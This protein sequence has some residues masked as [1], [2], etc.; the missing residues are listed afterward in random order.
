MA[1][2]QNLS[3]QSLKALGRM[4][5]RF[6]LNPV[7]LSSSIAPLERVQSDQ[8]RDQSVRS[9]HPVVYQGKQYTAVDVAEKEGDLHPE[10]MNL[11]K[12]KIKDKSSQPRAKRLP[13]ATTRE[14]N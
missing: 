11:Q 12:R 1:F 13:Q 5:R 14:R 7:A 2:N 3:E 8:A 10:D 9:E 4:S 6:P